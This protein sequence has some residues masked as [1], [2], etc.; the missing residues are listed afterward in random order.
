M[1]TKYPVGAIFSAA[2]AGIFSKWPK[3]QTE[4]NGISMGYGTGQGGGDG[5]DG[6][7]GGGGGGYCGYFSQKH[8]D[9]CTLQGGCT[10]HAGQFVLWEN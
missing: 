8:D 1:A 4:S 2:N 5:G 6:G 3:G 10:R 9:V 7:G